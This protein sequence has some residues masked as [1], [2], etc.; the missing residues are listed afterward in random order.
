MSTTALDA[1]QTAER[2]AASGRQL[3]A[4]I[5][6]KAARLLEAVARNWEAPARA[7]RLNEA[8][9]YNTKLWSVFQASM[10]EP[11]SPLPR[12]TRINILQLIRFID[13]RTLEIITRPEAALL[14]PLIDINRQIAAG[15]SVTEP[16][17]GERAA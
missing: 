5:L 14:Q 11:D 8:L 17:N 1:Y 10:E 13:K 4:A 2:A 7:E 9:D 6:F 3:E 16:G 12:E 15:L